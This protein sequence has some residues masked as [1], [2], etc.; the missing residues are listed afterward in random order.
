MTQKDKDHQADMYQEQRAEQSAMDKNKCNLC[1][2]ELTPEEEVDHD[3][4]CQDCF[5][6]WGN[7]WPDR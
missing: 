7:G 5:E 6:E 3:N 1:G 4:R 2:K